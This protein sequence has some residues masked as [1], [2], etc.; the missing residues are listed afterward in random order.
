MNNPVTKTI[1]EGDSVAVT[2]V[3]GKVTDGVALAVIRPRA[4]ADVIKTSP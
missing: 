3:A 4:D 1:S 2:G